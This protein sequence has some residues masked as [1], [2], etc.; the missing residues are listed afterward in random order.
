MTFQNYNVVYETQHCIYICGGY[1]TNVNNNVGST[2][3]ALRTTL[4]AITGIVSLT[5]LTGTIMLP[6]ILSP[7]LGVISTIFLA[8]AVVGTCPMYAALGLN[9]ESRG[10]GTS[11]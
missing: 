5:I 11:Q 7:V 10:P 2:D 9:S 1:T 8:T 3:R 4:G 6:E